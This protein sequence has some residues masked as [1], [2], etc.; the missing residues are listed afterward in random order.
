[1][2]GSGSW[3]L[4]RQ[5]AGSR[6][7]SGTQER[8]SG[9]L[10]RGQLSPSLM[11][12]IQKVLPGSCLWASEWTKSCTWRPGCRSRR[13][14]SGLPGWQLH[15]AAVQMCGQGHVPGEVFADCP[16]RGVTC[17]RCMN[18]TTPAGSAA[19]GAMPRVGCQPLSLGKQGLGC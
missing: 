2:E 17:L 10:D 4:N 13:S 6:S 5:E 1:M 18:C 14:C 11:Q 12:H 3:A 7:R 9:S 8:P 16:V 19:W 15:S